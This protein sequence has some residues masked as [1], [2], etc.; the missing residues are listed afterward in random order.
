VVNV[1]RAAMLAEGDRGVP[2]S[3]RGLLGL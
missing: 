2:P 1:E 3:M